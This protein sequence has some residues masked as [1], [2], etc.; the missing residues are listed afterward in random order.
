MSRGEAEPIQHPRTGIIPPAMLF[1]IHPFTDICF[2]QGAVIITSDISDDF[3]GNRARRVALETPPST[4]HSSSAITTVPKRIRSTSKTEPKPPTS[5]T[6]TTVIILS[7]LSQIQT[8]HNSSKSPHSDVF[9]DP[10]PISD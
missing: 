5:A 3:D 8:F 2:N 4:S 10:V 9:D 7:R 6:D 1:P